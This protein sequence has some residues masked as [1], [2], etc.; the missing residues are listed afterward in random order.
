MKSTEEI[1]A[2]IAAAKDE[3]LAITKPVARRVDA[4]TYRGSGKESVYYPDR[5]PNDV[6]ALEN[7]KKVIALKAEVNALCWALE[8]EFT[9]VDLSKSPAVNAAPE[10]I[11]D[12]SAPA[13]E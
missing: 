6:V 9:T 12:A 7:E 11:G 1:G 8:G 10:S 2:R 13:G 3:I 4:G 5:T